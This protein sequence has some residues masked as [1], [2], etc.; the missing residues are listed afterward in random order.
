MSTNQTANYQ[1]NQWTPEDPVLREEFN[2]DN[3]K[4][5]EALVKKFGLDFPAV[6]SGTYVGQYTGGNAVQITIDVGFRPSLVIVLTDAVEGRTNDYHALL[7][8]PST[9]LLLYGEY[10]D[11]LSDAIIFKNNGFTVNCCP[12]YQDGFNV[13]GVSYH[14]LAFR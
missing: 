12:T 7:G 6:Q 9:Q 4:I 2:T 10:T 14:Y 3:Q 5:D 11:L 1:L 13:S 8:L